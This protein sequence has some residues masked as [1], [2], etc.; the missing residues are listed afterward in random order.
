LARCCLAHAGG[1]VSTRRSIVVQPIVTVPPMI[2]A[3]S[4][5]RQEN[6]ARKPSAKS[7]EKI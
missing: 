5:C 1:I 2:T 6:S 3:A 7:G 4:G